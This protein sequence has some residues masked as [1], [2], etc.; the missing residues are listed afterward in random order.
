MTELKLDEVG[1]LAAI[2]A[3]KSVSPD[4]QEAAILALEEEHPG[5][6]GRARALL[7]LEKQAA[8]AIRKLEAQAARQT[9]EIAKSG[10]IVEQSKPVEEGEGGCWCCGC[11]C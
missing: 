7:A 8:E 4:Q 5:I 3:L 1:F 2:D 6:G 9:A 10:P 11:W